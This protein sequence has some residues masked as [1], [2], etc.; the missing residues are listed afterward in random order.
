MVQ[1]SWWNGWCS[2]PAN[3]PTWFYSAEKKTIFLLPY[4]ILFCR[5]K[6]QS[7]YYPTWFYSA[8]KKDILLTSH[9]SHIHTTKSQCISVRLVWQWSNIV[10]SHFSSLSCQK[11]CLPVRFAASQRQFCCQNKKRWFFYLVFNLYYIYIYIY[12]W[13]HWN[14][15]NTGTKTG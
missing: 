8:E 13:K 1:N 15:T 6:R 11:H 12:I 7:S 3:Y 14:V 2:H 10:Q 5:K 9:F 4:L